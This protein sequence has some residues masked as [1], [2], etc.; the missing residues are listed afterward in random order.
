MLSGDTGEPAAGD[1]WHPSTWGRVSLRLG[2]HHKGLKKKGGSRVDGF[3]C[4]YWPA[5]RMSPDTMPPVI[6]RPRLGPWQSRR[7]LTAMWTRT[8]GSG[9]D[10]VFIHGWTMDHRDE[11]RTYEPIFAGT[12]GW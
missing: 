3:S 6:A 1:I 9:R 10:V 7:E 2:N 5:P 8:E 12:S 11:A 4:R